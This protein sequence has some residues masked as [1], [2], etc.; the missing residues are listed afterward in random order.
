MTGNLR[1][2][3][4]LCALVVV[5][6]PVATADNHGFLEES[7]ARLQQL[8]EK[9]TGLAGAVP[10]DKYTY[11]PADGVRSMSEVLLHIATANYAVARAL[12]TPPPEGLNLRGLQSSTTDKAAIEERIKLSFDHLNGAVGKIAAGDADK[13]MRMFGNDT[14]TRGA[15]S[16]ATNHLSEHLG[17]SIAYAR[18]NG[19]TPPWSE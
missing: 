13:A 12:G 1:R 7:K 19:V 8:E 15:L 14:T 17:Q 6:M 18:V 2:T 4:L 11:R 16:I 10:A 9:F 3:A 5:A